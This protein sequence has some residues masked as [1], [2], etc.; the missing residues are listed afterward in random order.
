M[1]ILISKCENGTPVCP[2]C[3]CNASF[4]ELNTE[5]ILMAIERF[6]NLEAVRIFSYGRGTTFD[7]WL[8]LC[9]KLK[10]RRYLKIKGNSMVSI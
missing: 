7:F 3:E 10:R 1:C 9:S 2:T 8:L 4:I 6:P 5:R